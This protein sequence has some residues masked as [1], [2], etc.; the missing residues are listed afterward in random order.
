MIDNIIFLGTAGDAVVYGKQHRASGGI[1]LKLERMQFHLDPGP[2]AIVRAQQ[3]KLNIRETTAILV[4]N[5]SI[6]RS[7]DLNSLV[8]GMTYE[9]LDHKGVVIAKKNVVQ[10]S[11]ESLKTPILQDEA[12]NFIERIIGLEPDQRVGIG[13]IEIKSTFCHEVDSIG[14]KIITPH[15]IIG[16]TSDTEYSE[17]LVQEFKDCNILL[18]NC[19]NPESVTEKHAMN[20]LNVIKLAEKIKPDL[21]VMTGFG[22]KMLEQNP[23]AEAR[24]VQ[25]DTGIQVIAAKDG[26]IL[27]PDSYS[28]G[29]KQTQLANF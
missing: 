11:E 29:K 3:M 27:N 20:T 14:F 21:L 7:S 22:I 15:Y 13:N 17:K 6:L 4:S 9:G 12:K 10:A 5:R 26:L 23:I 16:Y 28:S 25:K 8:G 2:G 1:I 19:K 18:V 24:K